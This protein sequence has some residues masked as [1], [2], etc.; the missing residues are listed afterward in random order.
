MAIY[1]NDEPMTLEALSMYLRNLQGVAQQTAAEVV[2]A[3]RE[4]VESEFES[5]V[6]PYGRKWRK[7]A[8]STIEKGRKPP[9]LTDT[10]AMRASV[11]IHAS[12]ESVFLRVDSPAH[13]HQRGTAHMPARPILPEK[14]ALPNDWIAA[15]AETAKRIAGEK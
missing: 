10:G 11:E 1:S 2:P 4:F 5:G 13:F 12:G 14:T 3:F 15:I 7:L 6:D 8:K 9:P